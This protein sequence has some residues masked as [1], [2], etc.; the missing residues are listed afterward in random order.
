MDMAEVDKVDV[1]GGGD[2]KD[3]TV[4]RSPSKN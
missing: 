1:G 3:K 2:R 4:K